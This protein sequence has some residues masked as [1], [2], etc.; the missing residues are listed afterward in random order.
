VSK[1]DLSALP[2]MQL[3]VVSDTLPGTDLFTIA[4]QT[5]APEFQKVNGVS[6]VALSAAAARGSIAGELPTTLAS[7]A[8]LPLWLEVRNAGNATWPGLSVAPRGTVEIQ[9]RWRDARTGEVVVEGAPLPLG[10]DL[11]PGETMLAQVNVLAPAAP[12][13]YLLEVALEQSGHGWF[14]ELGGEAVVLRGQVA[15]TPAN[16]G[17]PASRSRRRDAS[18]VFA[19]A[20]SVPRSGRSAARRPARASRRGCRAPAGRSLATESSSTTGLPAQADRSTRA[21]RQP[22]SPTTIAGSTCARKSSA[23]GCAG[24]GPGLARRRW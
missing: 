22:R 23:G 14:D 16:V 17:A 4:D 18:A 8:H 12:G 2:V 10:R 11:G 20:S 6:Q 9:A 19:D 21:R 13:D 24:P 7:G 5:L 15:V 3:A 1:I